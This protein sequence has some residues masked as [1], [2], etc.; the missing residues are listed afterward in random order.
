MRATFCLLL[1]FFF[2]LQI[3][4]LAFGSVADVDSS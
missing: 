3:A 4:D 1:S 2:F